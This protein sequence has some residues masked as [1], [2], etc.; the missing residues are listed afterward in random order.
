MNE[1]GS[2]NGKTTERGGTSRHR[3]RSGGLYGHH[4][5]PTASRVCEDIPKLRAEYEAAQSSRF[6]ARPEGLPHHPAGFDWHIRQEGRWNY[7]L[8]SARHIELN[9]PVVPQGVE[10]FCENVV[11]GGYQIRPTTGN[12]SVDRLHEEMW[13]E[14][15]DPENRQGVDF[16]AKH[17]WHD[18]EM[19]SVRRILF[20]GDMFVKPIWE[21]GQ[22]Q[23]FEA[24]RCRTPVR[25]GRREIVHGVE[26]NSNRQVARYWITRREHSGI[27]PNHSLA[28][29]MRSDLKGVMAWIFD[30]LTGRNEPNMIHVYLPRR[31]SQNRGVSVL[32]PILITAAM[33]GDLQFAKLV[34]SHMVSAVGYSRF[35]P[36]NTDGFEPDDSFTDNLDIDPITGKY[37]SFHPTISPGQIYEPQYPGEELKALESKVPNPEFFDQSNMLLQFIAVNLGMPLILFLL[38]ARQTNLSSWRGTTDQAK[39]AFSNFQKRHSAALH[40]PV[41]RYKI[42]R[43]LRDDPSQRRVMRSMGQD[44]FRHMWGHPRWPYSDPLKDVQADAAEVAHTLN[45]PRRVLARRNLRYEEIVRERCEDTASLYWCAANHAMQ[46]NQHPYFE[47]FPEQRFNVREIASSPLAEGFQMQLLQGEPEPAESEEDET[48]SSPAGAGGNAS[49]G[50][51]TG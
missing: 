29:F 15:T 10:R 22:V 9:D 30:E 43:R 1:N 45:S 7:L 19:T 23:L 4:A 16:E 49:G 17:N 12:D 14:W 31:F 37:R 44:Y 46:L 6:L 35:I 3:T 50:R 13:E 42:R 8:E 40:T 39:L 24:H 20:D 51:T 5:L 27:H 2:T 34:Q 32:A 33:H 25:H 28:G 47:E 38:D 41:F 18:I 48:T 26:L 21:Q 36:Q 11:Q